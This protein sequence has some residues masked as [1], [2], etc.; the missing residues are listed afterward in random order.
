VFLKEARP[1][2]DT[3]THETFAAV[4]GRV[5]I[6]MTRGGSRRLR[7]SV[8]SDRDAE[9][10]AL[11]GEFGASVAFDAKSP[12]GKANRQGRT[13]GRRDLGRATRSKVR[14]ASS[15]RVRGCGRCPPRKETL[16]PEVGRCG[17]RASATDPME[18]QRTEIGRRAL[19]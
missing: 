8:E 9:F 16:Y 7:P 13:A 2:L 3:T 12:I 19:D 17:G 1:Y 4:D 10:K 14:S 5:E 15:T 11:A 18:R 6:P